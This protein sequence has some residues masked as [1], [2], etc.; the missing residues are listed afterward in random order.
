DFADPQNPMVEKLPFDLTRAGYRL[1]ITDT[2]GNHAALSGEYATIP[3]EMKEVAAFFNKSVLRDVT[4]EA[5]MANMAAIRAKCGD[6]ALLR[7]LHFL[8][9]N[10]RVE[11]QKEA[12]KKDDLDTFLALVLESGRSSAMY[13]QN[14]FTSLSVQEQGIMLAL[15]ISEQLLQDKKAAWRLH[16]GGFAG[17]IQA[18]VPWEYAAWYSGEMDKVFGK[19]ASRCLAVRGESGV[20]LV[21]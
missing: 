19:G 16:G 10:Q 8:R 7:A 9:E 12:L 21:K 2:G 3:G 18:F 17:T 1:V 13:L 15:C 14:A 4:Q 6:R 20:C 5:V 11:K